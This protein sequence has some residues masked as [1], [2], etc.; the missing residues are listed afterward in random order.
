[1]KT[2]ATKSEYELR[3][4][5]PADWQALKAARTAMVGDMQPSDEDYNYYKRDLSQPD[6]WWQEQAAGGIKLHFGLFRG[7]EIAGVTA[8]EVKP[9]EN[10][11]AIAHFTDTYIFEA[12]RGKWLS[13]LIYEGRLIAAGENPAFTSARLF[14]NPKNL[15]SQRAAERNGFAREKELNEYGA[16]VY[17]RPLP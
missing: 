11:K 2:L 7:D 16:L 1:M 17:W 12:H 14:V 5:E 4:F 3:G 13:G 9:G 10:G 8:I 15:K 6:S